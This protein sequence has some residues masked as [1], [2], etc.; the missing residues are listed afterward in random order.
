MMSTFCICQLAQACSLTPT[1]AAGLDVRHAH[2]AVWE[3]LRIALQQCLCGW[4]PG[5]TEQCL[6]KLRCAKL[7]HEVR[8]T[9][10]RLGVHAAQLETRQCNGV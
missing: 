5:C 10:L 4:Q 6:T 8:R 2:C 3:A 1:L 9:E 7:L